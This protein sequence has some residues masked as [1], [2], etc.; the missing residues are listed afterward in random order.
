MV[1]QAIPRK[2][3]FCPPLFTLVTGAVD[4]QPHPGDTT[5]ITVESE[6]RTDGGTNPL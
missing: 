2:I 6:V 4:E 5:E 1:H 3:S